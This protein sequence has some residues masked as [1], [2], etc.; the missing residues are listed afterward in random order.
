VPTQEVAADA[1]QAVETGRN[2][3]QSAPTG[4]STVVTNRGRVLQR[5]VLADRSV[6]YATVPLR[7]GFT[8]YDHVGDMPFLIL[9]VLALLA[10]WWRQ[11]KRLQGGSTNYS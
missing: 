6:L 11:R 1:I 5:S 10:G 8:L 9:F 4:Y 7:R 2:L 3:I